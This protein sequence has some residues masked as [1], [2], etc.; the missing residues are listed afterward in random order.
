MNDIKGLSNYLNQLSGAARG[1]SRT[2][3][4]RPQGLSD[5]DRARES[6][7]IV[8]TDRDTL[9]LTT[10]ATKLRDLTSGLDQIPAVDRKRVDAVRNALAEGSFRI[11]P[12]RVADKL[13]NIEQLLGG[14]APGLTRQ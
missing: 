2:D 12:E 13:M 6:G 9:S 8:E 3:A 14:A 1:V 11:N 7:E 5:S 10:A 4:A